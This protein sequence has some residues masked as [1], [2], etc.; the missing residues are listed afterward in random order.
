M[1]AKTQRK[2]PTYHSPAALVWA[3]EKAGWEQRKLAA[4]VG[5]SKA[6]LNMIEKGYRSAGP[7]L[8]RKLA[9]E[10]NCPISMLERKRDY[11]DAA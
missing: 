7:E 11:E 9:T 10:L 1:P 2:S 6:Y 3:R 4:E 5:I 8:L